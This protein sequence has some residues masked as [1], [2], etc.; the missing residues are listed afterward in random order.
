MSRQP[1][2]ALFAAATAFSTSSRAALREDADEVVRVG[3]IPVFERPSRSGRNP[4]A[5]DEVAS[6]ARPPARS[7]SGLF[8]PAGRGRLGA[9]RHG[10]VALEVGPFRDD[11]L[12]RLDAAVHDGG[13]A[14]SARS[15]ATICPRTLPPTMTVLAAT[16]PSRS[17]PEPI[18]TLRSPRTFPSICPS[19]SRS[20]SEITS[21]T[22]RD[23]DPMTVFEEE[24]AGTA[25]VEVT[26]INGRRSVP[27]KS[28]T[29]GWVFPN[30]VRGASWKRGGSICK[31]R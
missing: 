31:F 28:G 14:S 27:G 17:P 30:M 23:P 25:A 18:V 11:D 15:D 7:P 12:G 10:D 24:D 4:L 2:K 16:S 21:P 5:A 26:V 8:R 20:S 22:T 1:G 29:G 6:A 9:G 3:G 19:R 13:A